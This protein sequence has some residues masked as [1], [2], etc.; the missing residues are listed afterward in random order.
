MS[1]IGETWK[2]WRARAILAIAPLAV[3]LWSGCGDGRPERVPVSGRVLIDGKP[4][5]TGNI[6]IHPPA[7]RPASAKIQPDGSFTLS[8]YEFG[9]GAVTGTH[10]VTVTSI[11]MLSANTVR[12]LAP[13]KYTS[14]DTSG[15]QF[16]IT[17]PT[18]SAEINLS[19][20]GG[21]P[22]DERIAGGGD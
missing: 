7:N 2:P 5:E 1:T 10:P 16:E 13:K 6:R 18:D 17:G 21:K 8:T 4:L 19:W 15:L 11:K 12:W 14:A 3:A 22:F 9:D 20:E